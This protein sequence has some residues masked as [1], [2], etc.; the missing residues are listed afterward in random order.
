MELLTRILEEPLVAP[1]QGHPPSMRGW[2][3]RI[4]LGLPQVCT[5]ACQGSAG[6]KFRPRPPDLLAATPWP[7]W[8]TCL[9]GQASSVPQIPVSR[10]S[11]IH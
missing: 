5:A 11:A 1:P 6:A 10:T 4:R 9:R 7:P 8:V 2:Q 3:S